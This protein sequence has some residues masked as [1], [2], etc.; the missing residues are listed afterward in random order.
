MCDDIIGSARGESLCHW[1]LLQPRPQL[2]RV[3]PPH[4]RAES[5]GA[6]GAESIP[7]LLR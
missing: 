1:L 2:V 3:E 5:E 7:E 4:V 6:V